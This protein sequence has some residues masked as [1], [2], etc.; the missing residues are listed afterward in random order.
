MRFPLTA[1]DDQPGP[2][3]CRHIWTGGVAAQLVSIRTPETTPSRWGPRKPSHSAPWFI[4]VVLAVVGN[5]VAGASGSPADSAARSPETL[6]ATGAVATVA[7]SL[8]A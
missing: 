7:G 8:P 3:G 4:P 2:T 6:A 5:V 1:K